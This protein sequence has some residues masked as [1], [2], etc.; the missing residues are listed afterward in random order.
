MPG[1]PTRVIQ[2]T[3]LVL[4]ALL[5]VAASLVASCGGDGGRS[6]SASPEDAAATTRPPGTTPCNFEGQD[7]T[8]Y[9]N[10]VESFG[11]YFATLNDVLRDD[12]AAGAEAVDATSETSTG[13]EEQMKTGNLDGEGGA[14]ALMDSLIGQVNAIFADNPEPVNPAAQPPVDILS[15]LNR[16]R[17]RLTDVAVLCKDNI[18]AGG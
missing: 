8:D 11:E 13:I 16:Q 2:S 12:Y 3:G 6:P 15:S 5:A 9:N 17:E 4:A 18:A 7:L 14:V 10:I 1:H